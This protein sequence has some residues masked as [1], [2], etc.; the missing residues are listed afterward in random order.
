MSTEV[1]RP[2]KVVSVLFV[3]LIAVT[4]VSAGIVAYFVDQ[5]TRATAKERNTHG[6]YAL[7]CRDHAS[8]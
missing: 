8:T 2:G 6:G 7:I 4:V 3:S 1:V 5:L